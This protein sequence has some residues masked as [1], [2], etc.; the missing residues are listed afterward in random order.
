[1]IASLRGVLS[2]KDAEGATIEC[3]GV[4]Y[5][6]AASSQTLAALGPLGQ[7]VRLHVYTHVSEDALKLYG[8]VHSDE[9]RCFEVLLG[10]TGVGP[11][12]ALAI[13]S[14]LT[15]EHLLRAVS[16][17]DRSALTRIPGVGPKKADR[18]LLELSGRLTATQSYSAQGP[19]SLSDVA[20]A[21]THLGFDITQATEAASAAQSALPECTDVATLTK[22]ALQRISQS[23]HGS[24]H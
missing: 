22:H 23:A 10:T 19:S 12:L 8:F 21:L 11:R 4:G 14:T 5:G 7:E 24:R 15:P 17:K 2:Y 18:L 13:L 1:M 9:R 16:L 6:V 20:S 3:S